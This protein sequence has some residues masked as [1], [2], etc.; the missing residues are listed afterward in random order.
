MIQSCCRLAGSTTLVD[1]LTAPRGR[2]DLRLAISSNDTPALFNWLVEIFSFQGI[3]DQV[4][5]SY[6]S[7]HGNVTWVDVSKALSKAPQCTLLN[8]HWQF[9]GCRYNKSQRTCGQPHL[10]DR[11]PLPRHRL[12][13]GRLNQT[14]YSLYLFIRDVTDGDLVSWIDKQLVT[15]DLGDDY[16]ENA[17]QCLLVPLRNIF[18]VSDKILTMALSS[19]LLS[20]PESL[21]HW[22][23]VGAEMITV[24]TL[25]HNFLHRTGIL[26]RFGAQHTFGP[27]CYGPFGCAEILR[28]VAKRIDAKAFNPSFPS[29]FPRFVQHAVWR[30]CSQNGLNICNGNQIS[31]ERRCE[32]SYCRLRHTCDRMALAVKGQKRLKTSRF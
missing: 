5:A 29:N 6:L 12:R 20:A 25:V 18:G 4:A 1:D 7:A 8:S 2:H 14:A 27:R 23:L 3:S 16:Y 9:Y 15:N 24:D 30:Y 10:T 21:S 19:I 32:N 26:E 31:D 11:C 28:N 17:Q 13:N 22:R